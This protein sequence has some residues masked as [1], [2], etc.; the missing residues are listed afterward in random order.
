MNLLTLPAFA[1]AHAIDV[2]VESP[3]GSTVKLKY[4]PTLEAFGLSRPLP[5][6]L[7]YP[8][9]S[10][11]V[12]STR[13]SDG[14]R[15]L[16]RCDDGVREEGPDVSRMVRCRCGVRPGEIVEALTSKDYLR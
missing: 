9:D 15:V 7:V 13:A 10:G 4:E 6:G 11:F 1:S 8:Y 16:L 14:D 5:E 3:R 2:V 12:P